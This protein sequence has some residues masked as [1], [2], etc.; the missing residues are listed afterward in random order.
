MHFDAI[1]THWT[2]D[3]PHQKSDVPDPR[4]QIPIME[5]IRVFDEM[6]SRFRDDS[7]VTRISREAG[8][9]I[10]PDD[11]E[12]L[13]ALY[14]KLYDLTS[15]QVTPL[16]GDMLVDAGYDAAYSLT[17]KKPLEKPL[18]WDEAMDF[19]FPRLT[20]H[21]PA[22]LDFG[23]AGKGYLVDLVGEVLE[24][25]GI[26]SYIIDAGGDMLHRSPENEALRVGLEHPGNAAK[27][28]GVANI[29]NQS[30]CGSAINRRSWNDFNHVMNPRTLSSVKD[31]VATWVVADSTLV[32]DGLATALFFVSPN[33]LLSEYTF[34]Y[35]I[36]HADYSY[37]KSPGFPGEMF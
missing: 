8:E 16:V 30:I 23:A 21:Q 1:G 28:I 17:Q 10:L 31:I 33:I 37:E 19:D 27:A 13:F 20:M 32:A 4:L 2:I 11:S 14:R 6:Y 12:K 5:R 3:I 18:A 35:V 25:Q 26:D 24:E 34:E 22:L 36:V 9:Y 29:V 15:G 7:L